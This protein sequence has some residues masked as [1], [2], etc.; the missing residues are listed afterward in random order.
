MS[1]LSR[2][3]RLNE[4]RRVS[5]ARW[6][7][8]RALDDL[9]LPGAGARA[10]V[11]VPLAALQVQVVQLLEQWGIPASDAR[12]TASHLLYADVH[13]IAAHGCGML[14]EYHRGIA[15]GR[16]APRASV[17]VVRES[18]ATALVDGGGGLGHVPTD[19][20]MRLAIAKAKEAGIASVA[21]RNSG[22]FGAAGS[23]A[24]LAAAEGLVA[25]VTTNTRTPAVVPTSGREAMLGTNPIAFAAPVT[26]SAPFLLDMATSTAPVGRL[27]TAWREGRAVP[28]GWALDE[29]GQPLT[30]ARRAAEGRRLTP[31][32]STRLMGSHKGYALAAMVEILSAVLPGVRRA[33]RGM[34]VSAHRVGHWVLVLDPAQ[35]RGDAAFADDMR[36]FTGALR[37]TPPLDPAQPV[38]VAGDP[39][40]AAANESARRG[41]AL[42]RAVFEDLRGLC[43]RAGL[44]FTLDETAAPNG[45]A[46]ARPASSD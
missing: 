7:V 30:D 5:G 36:E 9:G 41:V 40:T 11:H 14:W 32:G 21:V 15:E 19:T 26:G 8:T 24:R 27:V 18:L 44:P 17:T 16:L 46:P 35:L 43:A 39:E 13:G 6:A 4:L 45:S 33:Q 28:V 42:S 2:L 12:V 25:M 29:N 38:Q 23:Y 37:A 34:P 3:S 10:G 1:L 22:H 31:L 20:A